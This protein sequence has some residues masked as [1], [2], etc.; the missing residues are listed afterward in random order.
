M[1]RE[2]GLDIF[3]PGN[4]AVPALTIHRAPG[5]MPSRVAENFYWLGRYLERLENAARL[6]RI[7]LRSAVARHA[8]CRAICRTWRR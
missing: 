1:L 2:E 4:L 5:E 8:C 3:G 6:I 7:V